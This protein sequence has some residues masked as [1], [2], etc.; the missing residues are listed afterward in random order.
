MDG[1]WSDFR[2]GVRDIALV[3]PGPFFVSLIAT[4]AAMGA[5]LTTLQAYVMV[6]VTFAGASQLAALELMLALIGPTD[7][8]LPD[9]REWL[10]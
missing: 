5:G 7:G 3:V 8:V 1:S 10:V 4:V 6:G 9:R 2:A